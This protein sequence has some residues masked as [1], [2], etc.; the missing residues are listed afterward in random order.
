M[1]TKIHESLAW[2]LSR[3]GVIL[4]LAFAPGLCGPADAQ[5]VVIV[6]GDPIT[7][8]DI[9]QR[10]K[11]NQLVTRKPANR[12]EV[13]EEL[14]NEKLKI[15]L[16]RRYKLEITDNDI[17][18]SYAEMGKRMNL[19]A[20]Q[21]T[22][23]LEKGGVDSGTLKSRIRADTTWQQIVRGK[24][25]SSFQFRDKDVL[26][27]IETRK[28]D[29]K[30]AEGT[31]K[32]TA[33]DYVLRPILFIVH[34]GAAQSA[35][36]ARQREA[37][38]LRSRFQD[39]EE[40]LKLARVLKDVAVR[41]QIT[42]NSADLAPALRDILD[43]TGVGRLTSPE[44][45]SDGVQVFA[46]CGKRETKVDAPAMRKARQEMIAEQ[47]QVKSKRLLDELRRAAL[48]EKK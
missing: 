23:T 30:D 40:G 18:S 11:F 22:Q 47:F 43:K 20:Q 15:Q 7:A 16:G 5:V 13:I 38:A 32:V 31:D 46:I 9:D 28:K 17:D 24:Y 3:L 42:R 14:I 34:K 1:S 33:H 29:D 10:A 44:T 41:D 45:T 48:I 2:T 26:A 37:E 25:Q 12:Q 39:C 36:E 21:L 6:N 8:Y 35:I 19:T 27:A 4:M